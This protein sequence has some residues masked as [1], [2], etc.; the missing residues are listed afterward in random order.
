MGR[1]RGSG[2]LTSYPAQSSGLDYA[3]DGSEVGQIAPFA[4]PTEAID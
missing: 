1:A 4:V 3:A 2:A